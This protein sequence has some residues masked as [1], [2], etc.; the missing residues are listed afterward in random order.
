MK[1]SVIVDGIN[2]PTEVEEFANFNTIEIEVGT[3]GYK[4]GDADKGCR[5]Y[6]RIKDLENT[7]MRCDFEPL[8]KGNSVGEVTITFG[9]DAELKTLID[10]LRFAVNTL[11]AK[12]NRH[13]ASILL[14][15]DEAG[16]L[17]QILQRNIRGGGGHDM[18]ASI[19]KDIKSKIEGRY[20]A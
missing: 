2:V 5:T 17:L 1:S 8:D 14:T 18:V 19:C 9:G 15:D 3:N 20:E 4:G 11:E 7:D 13:S 6:F 12:T 16:I 10:G